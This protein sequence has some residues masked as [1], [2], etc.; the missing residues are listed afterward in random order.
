MTANNICEKSRTGHMTTKSWLISSFFCNTRKRKS[1]QN[2]SGIGFTLLY[3]K[4]P[5]VPL[6]PET[7]MADVGKVISLGNIL[8]RKITWFVLTIT[9]ATLIFVPR[10][11][12][13]LHDKGCLYILSSSMNSLSYILTSRDSTLSLHFDF[14]KHLD[15]A[16]W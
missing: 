13:R 2:L 15:L 12:S 6:V 3:S 10:I 9:S 14:P 8:V 11:W 4:M 5:V 7:K 16:T 1:S